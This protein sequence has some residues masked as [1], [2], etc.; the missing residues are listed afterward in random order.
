MLD[1]GLITENEY[2][3]L[4]ACLIEAADKVANTASVYEAFLKDLKKSAIKPIVISKNEN[5]LFDVKYKIS[6]FEVG[7][8]EKEYTLEKL[9][10]II[11]TQKNNI[12]LVIENQLLIV[13]TNGKLVKRYE[14]SGSVKDLCFFEEGNSLAIIYRD[15]IDFIKNI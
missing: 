14:V 12:A 2:F 9:P 11:K 3:Y 1:K 13:N 7:G 5:G 8:E 10:T 15:K 6:I 4:L